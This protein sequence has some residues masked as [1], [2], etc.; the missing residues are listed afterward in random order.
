MLKY[1]VV[2]FLLSSLDA[3]TFSEKYSCYKEKLEKERDRFSYSRDVKAEFRR[4]NT[5]IDKLTDRRDVIDKARELRA[6][7]R[8]EIRRIF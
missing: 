2:A 1:I 7:V 6:S 3:G 5:D 8:T 4:W